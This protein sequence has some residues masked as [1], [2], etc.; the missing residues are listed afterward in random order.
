MGP[1]PLEIISRWMNKMTGHAVPVWN[2]YLPKGAAPLLP[3]TA[4]A[5]ATATEQVGA[6]C[7]DAPVLACARRAPRARTQLPTAPHA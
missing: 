2:P 4:P 6:A 7:L 3:P 5:A 1:K